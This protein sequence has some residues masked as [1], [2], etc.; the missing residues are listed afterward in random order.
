M[1]IPLTLAALLG[2]GPSVGLIWHYPFTDL[3][4]AA[5]AGTGVTT[6]TSRAAWA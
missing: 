1:L 6:M 2:T 3:G 4:T 5:V